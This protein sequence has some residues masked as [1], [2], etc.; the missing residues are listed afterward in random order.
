MEVDFTPMT[1]SE[2]VGYVI[3]AIVGLGLSV[4][5]GISGYLLLTAL[6]SNVLSWE[7]ALCAIG[8]AVIV[9]T[10]LM[11]LIWSITLL[12]ESIRFIAKHHGE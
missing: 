2:A 7:G 6:I 10:G 3:V 4:A 9:P 8:V 12:V 1:R 5:S 11:L